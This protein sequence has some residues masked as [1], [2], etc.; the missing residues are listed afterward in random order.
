V[1]NNGTWWVVLLAVKGK[2]RIENNI[3]SKALQVGIFKTNKIFS[4]FN[5]HSFG[6]VRL[7]EINLGKKN[8]SNFHKRKFIEYWHQLLTHKSYSLKLKM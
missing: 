3:S 5:L 6:T 1:G 2:E 8:L 7:I 4:R